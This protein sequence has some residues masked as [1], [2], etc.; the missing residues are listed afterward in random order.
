MGALD[1]D[2]F[3][4]FCTQVSEEALCALTIKWRHFARRAQLPPSGDWDSWLI[5][6]GRGFGK[7]RAGAGWVHECATAVPGTRIALIGAT[8]GDARAVMVEGE[9][10]LIATAAPGVRLHYE[11]SLRRLIW[12]NGAQAQLFSAQEPETLRGPQFHFA[13]G[14][15]A[16]RWTRGADVLANLRMGLRL[17][18]KPRLLL[19]TTPR[20]L[21][22][23]KALLRD[24]AC[25]VVR[26]GTLDNADNLP[27]AFID[28]VQRDYGGTRLGRQEL[29]GE[30][31]E[32]IEGAL[33]TRAMIEAARAPT[34]PAL[35]RVVVAVDPPASSG[36]HA[37]AC[38]I[39]VAALGS[40]GRGYVLAD[41]SVQG[42]T[43]DNWARAVV[44]A[45]D[46]FGADRVI[47]EA[48]NGGAMVVQVLRAVD[49]ALP[50]KAVHASRGKVARAEP[51]A[52]LYAAGKVSHVG[53][54]PALEDE[55]CGLVIGGGYAG[56][57]RSPDRAD[58]LV[59]ALT[60]LLLGRRTDGP[61]IRTI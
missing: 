21:P 47:A 12:P 9:S 31:I 53:A 45:A 14:D 36:A 37:D 26:G 41:R 10:G 15:E 2:R 61:R 44:A 16:A 43:P 52:S 5:L 13:W 50:V 49:A 23:L 8:L 58:A 24:A 18:A 38:G 22:W 6:A 35:A 1:D 40:D 56:P 20:P 57:G 19:T 11:P 4:A 3:A 29:D 51:V 60:E 48:N 34:V 54:F 27:R 55:M 46:E 59:W 32:D 25:R 42:A 30:L 33:W 7:T 39:V 28:A 17:G